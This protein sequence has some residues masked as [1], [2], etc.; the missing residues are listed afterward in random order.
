MVRWNFLEFRRVVCTPLFRHRVG[1]PN[2]VRQL[3]DL[4]APKN[5]VGSQDAALR[6]SCFLIGVGVLIAH[7]PQYPTSQS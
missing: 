5:G 1:I 2:Q 4:H 7:Q 6:R 3:V